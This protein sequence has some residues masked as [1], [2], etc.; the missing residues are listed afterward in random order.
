SQLPQLAQTF[1]NKHFKDSKIAMVTS[2]RDW[3]ILDKEYNVI[4]ANGDKIE[5]DSKGNWENIECRHASVPQHIVPTAITQH[6]SQAF[7]GTSIKEI[8]HDRRGYDVE[9]SNGV[10]V[11]FDNN[12]KAYKIDD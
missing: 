10:E 8:D 1:L 9:L 6:I 3:M 11:K 7:P 2:E 12:F 5:F 4:F